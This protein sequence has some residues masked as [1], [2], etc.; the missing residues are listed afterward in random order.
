MFGDES[1][2]ADI[3]KSGKTSS[4][5]SRT[6]LSSSVPQARQKIAQ[7]FSAGNVGGTGNDHYSSL[8]SSGFRGRGARDR[9]AVPVAV[10]RT[11]VLGYFL[12]SLR[13]LKKGM[14]T[15]ASRVPRTKVLGYFLPSL[16]D[17]EKG[18]GMPAGRVPGTKVLGYFLLSLRDLKKG[19]G[20]PA[21]R[22]PRTKVLGY[23]LPSLGDLGGKTRKMVG[24][25]GPR[26]SNSKSWAIFDRASGTKRRMT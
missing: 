13:D 24:G 3:Q 2:R 8:S 21:G 25:D 10:P 15:P 18:M 7:H 17:L 22:V 11:K 4:A 12:P 26:P 23:F 16:R 20:T 5:G 1:C 14:G 6:C 9:G 19:M